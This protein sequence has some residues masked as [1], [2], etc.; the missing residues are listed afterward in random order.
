[1]S[2]LFLRR[3]CAVLLTV[4]LA[5]C[6]ESQKFRVEGPETAANRA[7][8]QGTTVFA[9]QVYNLEPY[10]PQHWARLWQ[11]AYATV[12]GFLSSGAYTLRFTDGKTGEQILVATYS[13][14]P[15]L[16]FQHD[17]RL[18]SYQYSTRYS[19]IYSLPQPS[20]Y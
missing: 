3:W 9:F 13:L 18:T 10:N 7:D 2:S 17:I 1:M 14:T 11:E 4:V 6:T 16:L 15:D 20:L 19:D 8:D 5:S 12:N